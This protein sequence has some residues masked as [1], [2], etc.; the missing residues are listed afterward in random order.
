MAFPNKTLKLYDIVWG[1]TVIKDQ[2]I[3]RV[4]K[5]SSMQ[6]IKKIWISTYGYL[7]NLL[8]NATRYDHSI[9]VYLL[10]KKFKA[11]KNEQMAGLLHD[12]SHTAFSHVSTYAM[13]G[14]FD[15]VEF[16]DM[17]HD[18]IIKESGLE[19][20]LL[21]LGYKA[22]NRLHNHTHTLLE[23]NLPDIC[24]D[25]IDY[26]SRDGLHLQILSKEQADTI[27]KGITI[28]NNEFIFKDRDSAFVY[29]FT[30]YILN[31]MFYG[32]PSEAHFNNDFGNLVK[33][34][35]KIGVLNEKDWFTDDIF[36]L[37][38]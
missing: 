38:K 18:K 28:K 4:I 30:F 29:S 19:M 24:A 1:N 26:T 23:N 25:R 14:K 22:E 11:S 20:L 17:V 10:L 34:A 21:K 36:V 8:R 6:R 16:H 13:L 31:L 35:V 37:N 33:Y 15:G 5:H 12:V 27:L 3:Q 7:F 2:D 32:S 9:G